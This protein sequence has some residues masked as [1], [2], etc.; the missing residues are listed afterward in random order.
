MDSVAPDIRLPMLPVRALQRLYNGLPSLLKLPYRLSPCLIA[1]LPVIFKLKKIAAIA[2]KMHLP[3]AIA[4]SH[5]AT[6]N[7]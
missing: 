5:P 7:C 4:A 2:E 6:I 1:F 3:Q